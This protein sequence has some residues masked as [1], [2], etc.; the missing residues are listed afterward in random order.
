V[1]ALLPPAPDAASFEAL[2]RDDPRLLAG[3]AEVARRHGVASGSPVRFVDG[4]L[5]V[6]ALGDRSVLKLYPPCYRHE[7]AIEASALE[8]VD[9]RIGV[10]TPRVDARGDLDGWA[11]LLLSRLHG[12]PLATAWPRIPPVERARLAEALG[13]ALSSLHGID[14]DGLAVPR[15]DWPAFVREQV[16]SAAPRQRARGLGEPWLERIP[17]FLARVA[18]PADPPRV[19]LHTEV[20]RE[21]LLARESGG[22]WRLTGLFDF[23][24]S[25]VGAADYEFA[26]V[27][28]FATCGEPGLLR[29]LLLAYGMP[30][31]AIDDALSRRFLAY[32]LLHRYSNLP[33]YLRRLPPPPGVASLDA[34]ALHWWPPG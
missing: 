18:L 29:R 2:P 17:D 24:P 19:L 9:G 12:E 14:T 5:P 30:S 15:P 28:V 25:L 4:S 13:A 1:S 32:A 7:Q 34:L 16:E 22:R 31:G 8:A 27:G 21:H 11:Y 23:E 20:M 33:W 3:A 26:S 6:Y 10:P